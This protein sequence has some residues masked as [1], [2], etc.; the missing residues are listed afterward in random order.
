[1]S[2]GGGWY[3]AVWGRVRERQRE[4]AEGVYRGLKGAIIQEAQWVLCASIHSGIAGKGA[5]RRAAPCHNVYE[6]TAQETWSK[7]SVGG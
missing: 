2:G 5:G 7:G 3:R 4:R 1:M 6:H